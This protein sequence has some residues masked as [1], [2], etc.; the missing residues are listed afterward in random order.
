LDKVFISRFLE[1]T[2]VSN[3]PAGDEETEAEFCSGWIDARVEL[4]ERLVE[5]AVEAGGLGGPVVFEVLAGF[6]FAGQFEQRSDEGRGGVLDSLVAGFVG[7]AC[8]L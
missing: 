2:L 3:L 8:L 5:E 7:F 4:N 1:A 6:V